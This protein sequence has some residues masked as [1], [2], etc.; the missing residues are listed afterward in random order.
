MSSGEPCGRV[1]GGT[2]GTVRD[3]ATVYEGPVAVR[4]QLRAGERDIRRQRPM[5]RGACDCETVC[6]CVIALGDVCGDL[7]GSVNL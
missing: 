7:S 1:C 2:R 6:H 5:D 3:H 4:Q